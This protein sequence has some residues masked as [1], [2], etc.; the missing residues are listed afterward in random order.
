MKSKVKSLTSRL[1]IV[2]LIALAGVVVG[3]SAEADTWHWYNNVQPKDNHGYSANAPENWENADTGAHGVPTSG[4]YVVASYAAF[5]SD[6]T[7]RLAFGGVTITADTTGDFVDQGS[8]TLQAGG[9]GLVVQ[10]NVASL[11]AANGSILFVGSGEAVV[12]IQSAACVLTVI[13][14]LYGNAD[15]TLVKKGAGTLGANDY[16]FYS[17]E[18]REKLDGY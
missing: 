18:G 8:L 12:D 10:D 6:F 2:R 11:G 16:Y 9:P 3:L 13:K 5:G 15:V 17:G 14:S 4:D 7:D 1:Y